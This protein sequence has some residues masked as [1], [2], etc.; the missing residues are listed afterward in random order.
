MPDSQRVFDRFGESAAKRVRTDMRRR[1]FE[2]ET[3]KKL[4]YAFGFLSEISGKFD[5]VDAQ[6]GNLPQSAFKILLQIASH[7]VKL[8]ADFRQFFLV[9]S[10]RVL[11]IIHQNSASKTAG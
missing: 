9:L 6:I 5:F 8:Q 2:F 10:R 3:F 7:G 4:F 1:G 11:Y